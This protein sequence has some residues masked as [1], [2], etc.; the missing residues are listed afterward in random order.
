MA[1][2]DYL[3]KYSFQFLNGSIKSLPLHGWEILRIGFQ[4]LNGSIKSQ[5]ELYHLFDFTKFQFLNG[6]IKSI[7]PAFEDAIESYFNSS[8]VRLKEN[9][10]LD[11]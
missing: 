9:E 10:K 8:M 1:F 2:D 3:P 4:F 11:N 5:N 7:I 6:S